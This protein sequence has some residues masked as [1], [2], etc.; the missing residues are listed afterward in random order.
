MQQI[1]TDRKLLRGM[2]A[3][4]ENARNYVETYLCDA[5]LAVVSELI[6]D[7]HEPAGHELRSIVMIR[8][9]EPV[10]EPDETEEFLSRLGELVDALKV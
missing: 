5:L 6:P 4:A 3:E 7:D 10:V 1:L 9:D 2:R 8:A